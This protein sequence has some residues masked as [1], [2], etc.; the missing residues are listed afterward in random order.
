M[1]NQWTCCPIYQ[2]G[3]PGWNIQYHKGIEITKKQPL[4]WLLPW[5]NMLCCW[6]HQAPSCLRENYPLKFTMRCPT[7][8]GELLCTPGW[9][10]TTQYP[11]LQARP[12]K[13]HYT[14]NRT[15]ATEGGEKMGVLVW[16]IPPPFHHLTPT[17]LPPPANMYNMQTRSSS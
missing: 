5:I 8:I 1:I 10:E 11:L 14:W 6:E 4:S 7:R 9:E 17:V 13:M 3:D 12:V 2:I 15:W 16:H